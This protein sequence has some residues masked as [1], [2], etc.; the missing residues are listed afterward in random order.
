MIRFAQFMPFCQIILK[1]GKER[2]VERFHPWIFSG[3]IQKINGNVNN[4]DVVDVLSSDLSFLGR[5][6][7]HNGSISVRL[8]TFTEEEINQDFFTR[9][10]QK[11]FLLRKSISLLNSNA[12]NAWRLVHGEGD[13]LPGLIIDIYGKHA[14]I[15]C[16]HSGFYSHIN[17]ISKALQTVFGD[18]LITIFDKS[19][20]TL[21]KDSGIKEVSFLKGNTESEIISENNHQFEVNWVTGQKTGFFLDQR[22]SRKLLGEY[23]A[24]KKILNTFCYS[25][26]FSIYALNNDAK[27]VHSLDSSKK[28]IELTEKNVSLNK[29]PERHVSIVADAIPYMNNL[30]GKYD[31]I[32]LDPPAFAKHQSAKHNAVQAYRRL[33]EAAIRQINS[34][35][36]LFTFS[37]SQAIDK[38]LFRSILFSAAA[39]S[40]KQIK[41]LHQLHQGADHPVNIFHP[42][43]E[44]LK[45]LVLSIE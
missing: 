4:G 8:L 41:I 17:E 9:K 38:E 37:C 25:G 7:Y 36:L 30:T 42:E 18:K 5:G 35:G 19:K 43:G 22:D 1:K 34:G 28:A 32:I 13:E 16:H 2:S 40:K 20:E 27:E 33:N 45:G 12:T 15:Q 11:A 6:Y 23:A 21:G 26:G 31:I 3:A 10:I 44:Y 29:N 24:G 39:N 14:V